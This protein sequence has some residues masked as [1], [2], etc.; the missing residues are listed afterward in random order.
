M[1]IPET[2]I[3]TSA[4]VNT[5]AIMWRVIHRES[6]WMADTA[7]PQIAMTA[8]RNLCRLDKCDETVVPVWLGDQGKF[9]KWGD[10]F[11]AVEVSGNLLESIA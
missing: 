9:A 4:N 8:Y 11:P 2:Y 10:L 6:P 7:D 1:P 3:S 5:G